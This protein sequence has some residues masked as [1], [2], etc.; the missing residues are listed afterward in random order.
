MN[1]R[2]RKLIVGTAVVVASTA[3]FGESK[4]WHD[5]QSVEVT[6]KDAVEI[7]VD[8]P[9]VSNMRIICTE[10]KVVINTIVAR[11]GGDKDEH[12][13]RTELHEGEEE[14]IDIGENAKVTGFRISHDGKGRYKIDVK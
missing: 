3:A 14:V 2:I 11:I 10:G 8:R 9:G 6:G 13:V 1:A 5:V 4:S 7:G 12:P